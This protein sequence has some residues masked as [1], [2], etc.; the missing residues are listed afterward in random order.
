[1]TCG[2]LDPRLK[3]LGVIRKVGGGALDPDAGELDLTAGWGHAG[4]RGVCM[5]GKG[6]YEVRSAKDEKGNALLGETTLDVYLNG[7]AYWSNVPGGVWDYT[8][9]GY[10]VIKKWLSYRE[11]AMLG[12][13]LKLDEAEYVTEMVRRI[14][15]LILLQPELD[16]NYETSKSNT[17]RWPSGD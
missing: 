8:I 1:V 11:K 5:P 10:Q 14:A 7:V 16:A 3:D 2:T 15:A 17:W 9:G 4:A 12:R 13:G 6:K